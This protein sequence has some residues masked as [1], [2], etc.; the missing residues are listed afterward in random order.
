[1]LA[2]GVKLLAH[3]V[4]SERLHKHPQKRAEQGPRND[5]VGRQVEWSGVR[6][7][8]PLGLCAAEHSMENGLQRSTD[9]AAIV[10]M[11]S[12]PGLLR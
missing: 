2:H 9:H 3:G 4:R 1:M 7:R 6:D 5:P 12:S 11:C 8:C 10:I